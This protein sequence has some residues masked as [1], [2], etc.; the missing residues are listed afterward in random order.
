MEQLQKTIDKQKAQIKQFEEQEST[1][2]Q[3]ISNIQEQRDLS[4]A[5]NVSLAR[6]NLLLTR[7][8]AEM[9][10]CMD[11]CKEELSVEK[12]LTKKLKED[13][14]RMR[15][16]WDKSSMEYQAQFDRAEQWK[17]E[18]LKLDEEITKLKSKSL[19]VPFKTKKRKRRCVY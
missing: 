5:K 11:K 9:Q 14:I 6:N 12:E 13:S 7:S 16:E 19:S 15:Q 18:A 10:C 2:E 17:K 3:L 8:H 4:E 1:Y